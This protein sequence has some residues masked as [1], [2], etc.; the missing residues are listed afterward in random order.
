MDSG[1]TGKFFQYKNKKNCSES[2]VGALFRN[3]GSLTTDLMK[4]ASTLQ[5]TCSRN[6]TIDIGCV[7]N[8]AKFVP[9]NTELSRIVF[10]APLGRRTMKKLKAKTA[11]GTDDIPHIILHQLLRRAGIP[12]IP[13]VHIFFYNCALPA[14]WLLSLTN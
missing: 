11:G 3:D 1:N 14:S 13:D 4:K 10:S 7:P 12:F 9:L 6:F 5:Q 2:E 8:T